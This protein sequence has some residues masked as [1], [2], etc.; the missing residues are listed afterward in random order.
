MPD[1]LLKSALSKT[2]AQV[3]HRDLIVAKILVVASGGAII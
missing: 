1:Q 2:L 3:R